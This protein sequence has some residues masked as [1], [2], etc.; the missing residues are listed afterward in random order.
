MD[1]DGFDDKHLHGTSDLQAM[2]TIIAFMGSIG[3]LNLPYALK[4]AG[5]AGLPMVLMCG[6]MSLYT[7]RLLVASLHSSSDGKRYTSYAAIGEAAFGPSGRVLVQFFQTLTLMG[8]A[9]LTMMVAGGFCLEAIGGEPG[10][11]VFPHLSRDVW[12]T[13]CAEPD[14]WDVDFPS[15]AEHV[16]YQ[17][18]TGIVAGLALLAL[19]S[20]PTLGEARLTS[21]LGACAFV[22]LAVSDPSTC[23]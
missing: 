2:A 3:V 22:L 5:W 4:L 1:D 15:C 16:W 12:P 19:L 10:H 14:S 18:W 21:F 11:G 8:V 17:R 13:Y 9:S 23:P 6:A 7:A 20:M